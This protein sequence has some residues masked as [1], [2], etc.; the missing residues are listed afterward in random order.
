LCG[1][2]YGRS[3]EKLTGKIL[4]SRYRT[5]LLG[6]TRYILC[7]SIPPNQYRRCGNLV[8]VIQ[9]AEFVR[10][11]F[12]KEDNDKVIDSRSAEGG[13]VIRRRRE[14]VLC[15]RRF[16]TYERVELAVKLTVVKKDGSRVPYDRNRIVTGV[17]KACYKRPVSLQQIH[18]LAESVE[19]NLLRQPSQEVPWQLIGELT[20]LRLRDLDKVA[21]VRYASV[22]HD[23]QDL[24]QFIDEVQQ[25]MD[26]REDVSGQRE[27]FP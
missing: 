5:R 25:V 14:C 3:P 20:M 8:R 7:V 13:R 18:E 19:E 23:F 1:E 24:G 11:P 26:R 22:Y 2:R 17:Q 16:T 15:R 9:K 21:Y 10:C 12:C 27:L 6:L 4:I